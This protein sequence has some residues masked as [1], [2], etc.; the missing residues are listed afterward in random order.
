MTALFMLTPRCFAL[1]RSFCSSAG[2]RFLRVITLGALQMHHL[3]PHCAS[4]YRQKAG[5]TRV[6]V[7]SSRTVRARSYY[8]ALGGTAPPPPPFF[9]FFSAP[10]PPPPRA[11]TL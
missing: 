6:Q 11:F 5:D 3:L 8:S 10:P 4:P 9:R 1:L 2:G 7:P